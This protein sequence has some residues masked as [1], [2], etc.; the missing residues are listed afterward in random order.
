NPLLGPSGAAAVFGPQKGLDRPGVAEADDGLARL[1]ALLPA[2]A[3]MPGA[4]AAGGAGFALLAWGARL[5]PG[6]DAV[7]EL[8][9]LPTAIAGS[10]VV[11]TGEG[12]FDAQS[13][14]GKAPGHV[15]RLATAAGVPAALVAG[16]IAAA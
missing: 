4:G 10:A 6:A 3:S 1:A 5:V 12:A 13:A 15:A 2:D 8:V 14:A 16:R 9:G 7:A 11:V